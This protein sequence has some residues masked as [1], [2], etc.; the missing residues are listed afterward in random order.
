MQEAR[1]AILEDRFPQFLEDNVY[2]K[3]VR[4][5]PKK[6]HAKPDTKTLSKLAKN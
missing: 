2:S 5:H 1:K 4:D 3:I 6:I